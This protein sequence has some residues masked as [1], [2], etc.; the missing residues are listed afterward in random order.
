MVDYST[1][2]AQIHEKGVLQSPP[3]QNIQMMRAEPR[4]ED[5]SIN[6]VLRSG[7]TI[8]G[9]PQEERAEGGKRRDTATKKHD[10]EPEQG[11]K[12]SREAQRSFAATSTPGR[13]DQTEPR[14]DPSMI[15]T[16]LETC[17]KLLRDSKVIQGLQELITRCVG[18]GEP[19]VVQKIG[20]VC[21]PDGR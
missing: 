4:E 2:I 9:N 3:T 8:G 17:M 11:K 15:T 12:M 5:P 16:F 21:A 6:M 14:L 18:S 1:L 10:F 7:T 20:R 19:Q 13:R